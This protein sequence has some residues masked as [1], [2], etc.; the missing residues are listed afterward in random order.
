MEEGL[1]T[2]SPAGVETCILAGYESCEDCGF[3]PYAHSVAGDDVFTS[4]GA[5]GSNHTFPY[6]EDYYR[7][8]EDVY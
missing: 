5:A 8:E 6:K 7:D 3:D 2:G 4:P 1:L